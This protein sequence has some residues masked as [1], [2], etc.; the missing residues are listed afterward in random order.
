MTK[1]VLDAV[2]GDHAP[3]EAIAGVALA[4]QRGFVKPDQVLL[5][6]PRDQVVSLLKDGFK[7]A[8][9]DDGPA[10]APITHSDRLVLVDRERRIRGYYHGREAEDLARLTH[11]AQTLRG[12]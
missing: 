6:G 8:Y 1:V 9:A 11:D 2:G 4:V 12:G 7:V 3:D 5:T 10:E